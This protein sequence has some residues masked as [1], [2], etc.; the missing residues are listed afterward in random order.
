MNDYK[1]LV[2]QMRLCA[3]E[4]S[5]HCKECKFVDAVNNMCMNIMVNCAADAI[6]QLVKEK[7]A[8][9]A[10][11]KTVI[12][13]DDVNRFMN[14]IPPIEQFQLIDDIRCGLCPWCNEGVNEEMDYCS[15]CG[16][17]LDWDDR[18]S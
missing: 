14:K 16:Q 1:E 5:A 7:D 6:E 12:H 18:V 11:L 2:E 10:D 13:M 4:K 17:K 8:A 9:V 15:N 3:D